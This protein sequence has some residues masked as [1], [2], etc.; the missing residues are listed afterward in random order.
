LTESMT[1]VC[2]CG[3]GTCTEQIELDIPTYERIRADAALF[4]VRPGHIF[5]EVEDLVEQADG[6]DLVRKSSGEARRLA[7][8]HDPRS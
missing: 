8:E 6:Y 2:E 4:V 1:V 3:D 5:A 7:E